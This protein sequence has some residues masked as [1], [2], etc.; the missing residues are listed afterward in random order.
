MH[1]CGW[2]RWAGSCMYEF[3][4]Y[5]TLVVHV[6]LLH[7]FAYRKTERDR[8]MDRVRERTCTGRSLV[9]MSIAIL[10]SLRRRASKQH[11]KH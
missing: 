3:T 7:M 5:F 11:I 1:L 2:W 10:M 8:E 4:L 9:C 6:V